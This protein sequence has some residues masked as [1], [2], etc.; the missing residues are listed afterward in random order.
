MPVKEIIKFTGAF[1]LLTTFISCGAT[2]K[3]ASTVSAKTDPIVIR[4]EADVANNVGQY[5]RL[6]GTVLNSK[7]PLLLGV[8][9]SCDSLDLRNEKAWAEGI[10]EQTVVKESEVDPYSG[11]RGAGTYYQL[12]DPGSKRLANVRPLK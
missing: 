2:E 5:V 4:T 8:D 11:G 7:M 6:E 3:V 1:C 12:I 9:I 10:L